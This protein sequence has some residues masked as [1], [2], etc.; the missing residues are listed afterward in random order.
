MLAIG[1]VILRAFNFVF[2][3]VALG[4]TGSLAATTIRHHNPQVNFAVFAAAFG[5]LTSSIYGVF[6]YFISALAWPV[7]LFL[8]D[9]LNFVFTFA[10]ATAIAAAIRVHSCGNDEYV[11][12]NKVSQGSS[13][14]CRKAQASVAFLYFSAF[15]FIA[16]GIFSA[17]SLFRGGLF[18]HRSRPAPRTG[19][20]TMSQV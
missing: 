6:A 11:D 17:I 18:G 9:F 4:L 2:L 19:V 16:S 13:A 8:F 10:G 7:I 1:D 3:A 20:P 14:R 12:R 15:I 5:L